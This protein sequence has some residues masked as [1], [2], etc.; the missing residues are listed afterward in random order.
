MQI[1]S[2]GGEEGG[3]DPPSKIASTRLSIKKRKK[4]KEKKKKKERIGFLRPVTHLRSTMAA[5]MIGAWHV[6][7]S[8][9]CFLDKGEKRGC[10]ARLTRDRSGGSVL[11]PDLR[12]PINNAPLCA[13]PPILSRESVHVEADVDR[14][15]FRLGHRSV[16]LSIPCLERCY[17]E[18]GV[19][20]R[21]INDLAGG[22][23]GEALSSMGLIGK[24]YVSWVRKIW[25]NWKKKKNKLVGWYNYLWILVFL[26]VKD[27]LLIKSLMWRFVKS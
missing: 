13:T 26:N 4:K 1:Q 16:K 10:S 22:R 17:A 2:R 9:Q 12:P 8:R 19:E 27:V 24:R 23:V 21:V 25:R 14:P 5:T 15:G 3:L 20:M 18:N 11:D 7:G 6:G